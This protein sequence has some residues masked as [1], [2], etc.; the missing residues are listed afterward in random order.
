LHGG[1][2]AGVQIPLRLYCSSEIDPDAVTV[3]EQSFATAGVPPHVEL[4]DVRCLDDGYIARFAEAAELDLVIGGS[5]CQ[6][7]SRLAGPG[8]LG[9]GG[10]KSKLFYECA[11]AA[12]HEPLAKLA[13]SSV[14]L[15]FIGGAIYKV[16]VERPAAK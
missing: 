3:V 15:C 12:F 16:H 2:R 6:D 9:L 5:P 11:H 14:P 7:L 10:P 1:I 4:G 13:F 8:R